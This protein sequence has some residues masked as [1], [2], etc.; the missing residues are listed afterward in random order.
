M[1]HLLAALALL[2]A[3]PSAGRADEAVGRVTLG[4][5][6]DQRREAVA[7]LAVETRR[8]FGR[9]VALS[10]SGRASA[11][12]SAASLSLGAPGL[13]GGSPAVGLALGLGRVRGGGQVPFDVTRMQGDVVLSWHGVAG[14][15]LDLRFG[16]RRADV[17]AAAG[18]TSV[19][20]TADAGDRS[21]L[22]AGA[23]WTRA[24]GAAGGTSGRVGLLGEV[25]STSDGRTVTRGAISF[26]M[27]TAPVG[28]AVFRLNTRAGAV[29]ASGIGT[30][31]DERS[32]LGSDALRGF[33][34]AGIGPR[35]L[36][37][38]QSEALGG[39]TFVAAQFEMA[40]PDRIALGGLTPAAFVDVGSVWGLDR[41]GG[42]P[43]G[44][45]PVDDSLIWRASV[46]L[47][48]GYAFD[49]GQLDLSVAHP[50]EKAAYDRTETLQIS[51]RTRF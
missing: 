35:D 48:V 40:F 9:D 44:A 26:G 3:L 10:F 1:R 45:N 51:F 23:V 42:G 41:T 19:L 11:S 7:E 36:A 21:A 20:V 38:G 46:G 28:P 34:F 13:I 47:S 24:F 15:D 49:G 33:A 32:F 37:T 14:G 30:R 22:S 2:V 8:L 17:D 29:A 43:G 12:E 25:L 16:A 6:V 50:L 39:N 27:E 5:G 31:I 4:F 18:V